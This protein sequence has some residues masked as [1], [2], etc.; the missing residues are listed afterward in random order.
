M[1]TIYKVGLAVGVVGVGTAVGVTIYRRR[2][3]AAAAAPAVAPGQK[4]PML[5]S[6]TSPG[7]AVLLPIAAPPG[8]NWDD[9]SP[10]MMT[11][12]PEA[13]ERGVAHG[14][15]E[16]LTGA[17][18]RAVPTEDI[19]NLPTPDSRLAYDRGYND[20]Y[21]QGKKVSIRGAAMNVGAPYGGIGQIVGAPYGGIGQIVGDRGAHMQTPP[22]H[23]HQQHYAPQPQYAPQRAGAAPDQGAVVKDGMLMAADTA[24]SPQ[25]AAFLQKLAGTL[26]E[27]RAALVNPPPEAPTFGICPFCKGPGIRRNEAAAQ[28]TACEKG[29]EWHYVNGVMHMG[30]LNPGQTSHTSCV[31]LPQMRSD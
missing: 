16:A 30:P 13:Y 15:S 6:M 9:A 22:Q 29:H 5:P 24:S 8:V 21:D 2:K 12:Q 26:P 18:R 7:G 27:A 28:S 31:I 19:A 17:P 23:V 10:V 25:M 3:A 14:M 11:K 20:G 1:K 4:A